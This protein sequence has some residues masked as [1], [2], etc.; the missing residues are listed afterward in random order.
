MALI[1][2]AGLLLAVFGAGVAV[3]RHVEKVERFIDTKEDKE[4]GNTN[5]KDRQ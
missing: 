3:G 4:H 1:G 5:K 2:T